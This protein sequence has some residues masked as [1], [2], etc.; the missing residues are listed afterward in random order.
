[1]NTRNS[2]EKKPAGKVFYIT[3][4]IALVAVVASIFA[5]RYTSNRLTE[6]VPNEPMSDFD[7]PSITTDAGND[8]SSVPD[9]RDELTEPTEPEVQTTEPTTEPLTETTEEST[10]SAV[11]EI[12]NTEFGLP[13]GE[14]DAVKDYS[15]TVP[16]QST[17]MGDWRVHNGID[18]EAAENDEVHSVGNGVVTKVISDPKW[19]YVIEVDHGTFTG[20]YCSLSQEDAVGIGTTL[21]T[22]DVIG[23]VASIPIET[24]DGYHLHF[25]AVKDGAYMDPLEALSIGE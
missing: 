25:E 18:F 20:R 12:T 7:I 2:Y 13:L 15:P 9:T 24:E 17:T 23:R 21:S 19:G 8:V 16:I 4:A 3:C 22:G 5:I 11:A 1:M 14:T 10:K 6:I